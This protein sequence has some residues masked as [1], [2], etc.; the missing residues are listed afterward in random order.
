MG[1]QVLCGA[2][3]NWYHDLRDKDCTAD[4][5]VNSEEGR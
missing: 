4:K 2:V 3:K 1:T 5:P